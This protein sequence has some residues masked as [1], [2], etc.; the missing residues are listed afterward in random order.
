MHLGYNIFYSQSK[1][2]NTF[3]MLELINSLWLR[4]FLIFFLVLFIL[5]FFFSES[6]VGFFLSYLLLYKYTTL[7]IIV[8]LAGFC[9]PI[10]INILLMAVGALSLEGNF[11]FY[12]A[13]V[14]GSIANLLGDVAALFIFRRYGHAILRDKFVQKYSF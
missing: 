2:Y 9:V 6:L 10:P 13:L 5:V 8:F 4:V 14:T 3:P 12:L 11:N 7:F 1:C